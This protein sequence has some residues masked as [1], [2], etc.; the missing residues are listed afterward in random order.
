MRAFVLGMALSGLQLVARADGLSVESFNHAGRLTFNEIPTAT[1]YRVESAPAPGGS[2][3][4]AS[5]GAAPITL[6]ASGSGS[7]TCSVPM[8]V[9]RQFYRVV[10]T[11]TNASP[12]DVPSFL[13]LVPGGTNSGNDPDLGAYSLTVATFYMDPR[14]VTKAMWDEVRIWSA[15]YG[16]AYDNVGSGKGTN[17][18]V[19]GV[20]WY[21]CVKWCNARSE[22]EGL[23]PVYYADSDMYTVYRTGLVVAPYVNSAANGY[24]LPTVTEWQYAAR[25]GV[26][27]GRFPWSDSDTIQHARA[28]YFSELFDR[29][30]YDT[31]AT[32]QWHPDYDTGSMPYTSPVGSFA[33]TGAG[34]YDLAGNVSEW[35]YDW[36]PGNENTYRTISGGSWNGPAET[37][38]IAETGLA[39]PNGANTSYGFRTV[40]N[41]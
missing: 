8:D 2:W 18:P 32:Q 40:R 6:V 19:Q 31:S 39:S 35:C 29:A 12:Q 26:A 1:V 41:P 10:A 13:V 23:T 17:H 22:K 7:V 11:V 34:L 16:Y 37:C 28:N 3:R 38:R 21:D 33:P 15:S 5:N 9:A 4:A 20:N 24:R 27:N 36:Y 30:V 25:G 14:E